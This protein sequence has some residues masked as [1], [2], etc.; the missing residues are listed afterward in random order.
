MESDTDHVFALARVRK[1]HNEG[2]KRIGDLFSNECVNRNKVGASSHDEI[3]L[4]YT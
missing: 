1:Q 3:Y 4:F 2:A